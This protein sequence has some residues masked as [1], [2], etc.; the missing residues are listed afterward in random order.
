MT[1]YEAILYEDQ[2]KLPKF[3]NPAVIEKTYN[4]FVKFHHALLYSA[5]DKFPFFIVQFVTL[6]RGRYITLRKV[7][8]LTN[9]AAFGCSW[10]SG[11]CYTLLVFM[12]SEGFFFAMIKPLLGC[13]ILQK[14]A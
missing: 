7:S 13:S 3:R 14:A 1:R 8:S 2:L 5:W 11:R 9:S 4:L 10:A 6:L 12:W